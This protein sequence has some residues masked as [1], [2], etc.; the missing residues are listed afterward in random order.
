[1]LRGWI[2]TVVQPKLVH[3]LDGIKGHR[4]FANG[5]GSV[6]EG[7]DELLGSV[8]E[9]AQGRRR[10]RLDAKD[11]LVH[12]LEERCTRV[13]ISVSNNI[14]ENDNTQRRTNVKA[15]NNPSQY[16]LPHSYKCS[17]Q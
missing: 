15:G 4:L 16:M 9:V 10:S 7:N 8:S 14:R 2:L 12:C 6:L 5:C 11:G 1:M 17:H 13:S 3:Q